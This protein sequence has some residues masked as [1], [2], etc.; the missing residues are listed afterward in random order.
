MHLYNPAAEDPATPIRIAQNPSEENLS[1][2][3][4]SPANEPELV[5]RAL[6]GEESAWVE[7][8]RCHQQAV[9]RMA[10]L[11]LTNREEAED[12]A[13]ETFLR[14]FASLSRFDRDRPL[15]PWLLRIA[16]N[17]ALNRRRGLNRAWRAVQRFVAGA[18]SSGT[19]PDPTSQHDDTEQLWQAVRRLS[20]ADQQII[21]LRYF[22]GLSVQEC[23][24][25]LEI[26]EGTVKSRLSR[27]LSRLQGLLA[28]ESGEL[29]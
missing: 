27:A 2:E 14:A 20:P 9:F 13:Q 5:T 6:A 23:A 10:W 25:S 12:V 26:A 8:I 17:L 11:L 29:A 19:V 18:P 28:W 24:Q 21:Y 1:T 4:P 22:L 7:L 3:M 15:R 16:H